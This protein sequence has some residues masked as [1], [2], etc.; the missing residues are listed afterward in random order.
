MKEAE[1]EIEAVY[2]NQVRSGLED[3]RKESGCYSKYREKALAHVQQG[4]TNHD[5]ITRRFCCSLPSGLTAQKGH[6]I[7]FPAGQNPKHALRCPGI[8]P[9]PKG[10]EGGGSLCQ[11]SHFSQ[12]PTQPTKRAGSSP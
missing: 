4:M 5:P 7:N 3:H 1:A 8:Q 9:E 6:F 2:G 12:I 10:P 11:G